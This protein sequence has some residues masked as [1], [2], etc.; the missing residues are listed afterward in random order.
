MFNVYEQQN[1]FKQSQSEM[2]IGGVD[3]GGNWSEMMYKHLFDHL[4]N[5]NLMGKVYVIYSFNIFVYWSTINFDPSEL[6]N[7][8]VTHI[9]PCSEIN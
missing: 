9:W 5:V 1:G 8:N 3:L 2:L 7:Y 6:Q 4:N